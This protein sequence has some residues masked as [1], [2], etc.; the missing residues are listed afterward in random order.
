MSLRSNERQSSRILLSTLALLAACADEHGALGD[1]RYGIAQEPIIGGFLA[2]EDL[3]DVTGALVAVHADEELVFCTATLI[4]PEVIVTAKHCAKAFVELERAGSVIEW[5]TGADALSPASRLRVVATQSAPGDV[6]GYVGEG[7]DV[8]VALLEQPVASEPVELAPLDESWLGRSLI[9]LGYGVFSPSG[10]S[11]GRRRVGRETVSA[12]SGRV[13]EA[14]FGDFESFVE[15]TMTRQSTDA[16]LIATTPADEVDVLRTQYELALL[17]D[18]H[19]A[20]GGGAAEDSLTCRGDSGGPLLGVN[21]DGRFV[22]HGV[23]SGGPDS[24][25]SECEFGSVYAT[26]GPVT[27]PFLIESR[28]WTDPCGELDAAG[29]CDGDVLERCATNLGANLR[30]L[31]RE[32]CAVQ[33]LVCIGGDLASGG[34]AECADGR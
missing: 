30:R 8:A 26:F 24:V 5:R 23:I 31:E 28:S 6:G 21:A 17:F 15:W 25:R 3:Y 7:R 16:D 18:G 22:S 27:L 29:R 9:T 19:E 2:D 10:A 11:D 14:L 13:H 1:V 20:V 33:G 32:D 34:S 12:L 4:G